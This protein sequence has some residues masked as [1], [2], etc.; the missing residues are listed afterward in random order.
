MWNQ[1]VCGGGGGGVMETRLHLRSRSRVTLLSPHMTLTEEGQ[2]GREG[3]QCDGDQLAHTVPEQQVE[4]GHQLGHQQG[5]QVTGLG[6]EQELEHLLKGGRV[7]RG[8][9]EGREGQ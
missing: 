4:A 2:A 7:G 3:G 5:A 6:G 8:E 1:C 9:G